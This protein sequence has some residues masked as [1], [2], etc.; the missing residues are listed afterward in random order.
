[1]TTHTWLLEVQLGKISLFRFS[2]EST[3]GSCISQV[4]PI[5]SKPL[6]KISD[7]ELRTSST[8]DLYVAP[9]TYTLLPFSPL[10]YK[11][12]LLRLLLGMLELILTPNFDIGKS[13]S[14]S[15]ELK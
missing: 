6:H 12:S 11:L 15:H 8:S 1:M 3:N 10:T 7:G 14:L 9:S 4:A 5:F 13:N 2:K